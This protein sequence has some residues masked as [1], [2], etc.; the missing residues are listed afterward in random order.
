MRGLYRFKEGS[1]NDLFV[2]ASGP[3]FSVVG[4]VANISVVGVTY[5]YIDDDVPH[6]DFVSVDIFSLGRKLDLQGL[7]CKVNQNVPVENSNPYITIRVRRCSLQ[8][9]NIAEEQAKL[10]WLWFGR[11]LLLR[12]RQAC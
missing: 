6:P 3:G 11:R 1:R 4:E 8:F 9:L 12:K 10:L 5:D 2:H 7:Q